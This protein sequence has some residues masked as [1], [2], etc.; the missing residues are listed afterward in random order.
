MSEPTNPAPTAADTAPKPAGRPKK[1]ASAS[2]VAR[3]AEAQDGYVTIEQCGVP[4]AIPIRGKIPV[5]ATDAFRAGDSYEG[6]KQIIGAQQW[7]R[8]SDAGMTMDGLEEL[9]AKLKEALGN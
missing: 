8:L 3:Q 2:A 1:R 4:L 7:Q 9:A 5:A 6:T